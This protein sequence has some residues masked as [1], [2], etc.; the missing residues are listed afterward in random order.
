MTT[1]RKVIPLWT[2]RSLG[3]ID[4]A[5]NGDVGCGE[6]SIRLL[7]CGG[8]EDL[9]SNLEVRG[10]SRRIARD[11]YAGGHGD[12]FLTVLVFDQQILAILPG[13][14]RRDIGI[15]HRAS[16]PAIPTALAVRHAG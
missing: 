13:N 15:G 16:G 11:R 3:R 4:I 5:T 7:L 9:G 10:T 14:G 12:F 6:R 2:Y 1:R 8:D